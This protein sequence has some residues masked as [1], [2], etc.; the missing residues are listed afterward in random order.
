MFPL[1]VMACL[2]YINPERLNFRIYPTWPLWTVSLIY[3]FW[4]THTMGFD[5]PQ[6]YAH[7]Y[8]MPEFASLKLYA[9]QPLYRLYTFFATLPNYLE[10]LVR[11]QG[12]IWNVLSLFSRVF[13]LHQH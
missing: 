11:P 8:G 3:T 6:T 9:D 2:F 10:L 5:G 7:F 12:C 1:L 13:G 4:R